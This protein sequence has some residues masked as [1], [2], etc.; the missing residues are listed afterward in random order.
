L[1]TSSAAAPQPKI[2][3]ANLRWRLAP[4]IAAHARRWGDETAVY[5]AGAGETMVVSE[6]GATA[7]AGILAGC[8]DLAALE[9]WCREHGF[10]EADDKL[11][12]GLLALL[13]KLA[14]FEIIEPAP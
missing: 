4:G 9:D 5:F 10:A 2:P 13:E 3:P 1:K 12:E 7:I 8:S 11:V 14:A 6:V